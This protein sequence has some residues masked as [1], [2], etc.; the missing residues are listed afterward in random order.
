M[1][2]VIERLKSTFH[3]VKK[4]KLHLENGKGP[5][6]PISIE[7]LQQS[8]QE[9]FGV[10]IEKSEVHIITKSVG[11]FYERHSEKL[12]KIYVSG[13]QAS[14]MV[15]YVLTKEMCHI[16][17]DQPNE[18]SPHG[19]R[20]IAAILN[21]MSSEL[22][23]FFGDENNQIRSEQ[24]AELAAIEF[25]YPYELRGPDRLKIRPTGASYSSLARHYGI[26][27]FVV[28]RALSK[29]YHAACK[30]VWDTLI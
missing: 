2:Q 16:V 5:K 28:A 6:I 26:P 29:S 27:E 10:K 15:R 3:S 20:T 24:L 9:V 18:R 30:T 22:M 19:D 13:G 1:Q 17:V 25:L 14:E 11:G 21:F 8:I 12:A 23:P 7:D 4:V